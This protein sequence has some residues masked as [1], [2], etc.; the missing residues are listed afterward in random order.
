VTEVEVEA[1]N[2]PLPTLSLEGIDCQDDAS[3][4]P[5]HQVAVALWMRNVFA[6]GTTGFQAFVEFDDSLLTYRDDLSSYTGGPFPAHIL[7]FG[8]LPP[9]NIEWAAGRLRLDGSTLPFA[10]AAVGNAPLATLI[11]DVLD[12]CGTTTLNFGG[13]PALP[14]FFSELSLFG[15]PLATVLTPTDPLQLDVT[16]PVVTCPADITVAADVTIPVLTPIC[17]ASNC[18][19]LHPGLGCS[20]AACTS[21]ICGLDA[22]C[23]AVAWDSICASAA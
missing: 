2:L 22:F 18:C 16:D 23:C 10:P 6:P 5:G 21:L 15:S 9:F 1:T 17:A 3:P 12:E 11:F 7:N 20:D 4:A 14:F 19:S 8:V 13:Y